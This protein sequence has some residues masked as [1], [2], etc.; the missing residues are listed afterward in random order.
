MDFTRTKEFQSI[1]L[2]NYWILRNTL[3]IFQTFDQQRCQK[4]SYLKRTS[5]FGQL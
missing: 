2:S 5:R 3:T 4:L 1:F